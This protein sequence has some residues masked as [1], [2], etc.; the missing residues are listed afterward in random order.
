[1][2]MRLDLVDVFVNGA[3]S[4]N[5]LA[6]VHGAD[7]MSD[8]AMQ[9]LA[10]W[11]GFSETTFLLRPTDPEA[12]YRVRIFTPT[13][14]LPFAGH[15]TLGSAYAWR[16]AGGVAKGERIMQECGVGLVPVRVTEAGLAF[17]APPLRRSGPL[18]D[19]EKAAAL[20]QLRL[21]PED[22][23]EAVHVDNGPPWQ[24]L[25]LAS[26]QAVL[27]VSPVVT[28]QGVVDLGLIGPS[29]EPGVD[30]EIRGFFTGPGGIL[31]EDPVT[32]SLNAGAALYLYESGLATGDYVA[33]QG[34][35]IGADGRVHVSRD[36]EGVWIAG[37]VRAVGAG[38]DLA[39]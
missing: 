7:G 4:G 19:T 33:A 2:A 17:R 12:D 36:E 20:A 38:A 14:E 30:W 34:R 26:A 32:G 15:P 18:S 27:A 3:L 24:L 29:D 23:I 21:S 5:P 22:V 10:R 25:R 31:V 13:L 39:M 37:Q 11:I 35:R 8:A 6:V 28:A 9:S 16:A 1:M